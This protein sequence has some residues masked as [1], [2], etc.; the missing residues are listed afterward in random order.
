MSS[1]SEELELE[2]TFV[3]AGHTTNIVDAYHSGDV[4][5]LSSIS[6]AFPYSVVEG[7]MTGK[8]VVATDV[9]GIS[10]ALGNSGYLV[11]PRDSEGFAT[12]ITSLLKDSNLR[13]TMGKKAKERALAHF[14][15]GKYSI[16]IQKAILN[17][18]HMLLKK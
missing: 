2:E 4:I 12:A 11:K 14:T 8:P 1:P 18:L 5:A 9:G 15:L 10:E 13:Q 7:M 3:F 17:S 6:E 16:A